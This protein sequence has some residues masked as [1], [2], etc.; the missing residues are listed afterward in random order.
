M[1]PTSQNSKTVQQPRLEDQTLFTDTMRALLST[2]TLEYKGLTG[3]ERSPQT[4]PIH[5]NHDVFSDRNQGASSLQVHSIGCDTKLKSDGRHVYVMNCH[6]AVIAGDRYLNV[7]WP[8]VCYIIELNV[9]H[10]HRQETTGIHRLH[11]MPTGVDRE[12]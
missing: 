10:L 2:E 9:K 11:T 3:R 1:R 7:I 6:R 12:R 8:H 5:R 4:F